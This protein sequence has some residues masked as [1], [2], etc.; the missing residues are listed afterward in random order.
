MS[1]TV[2]QRVMVRMLYDA[3]YARRVVH[4]PDDALAGEDLTPEE[5]EW[6]RKPDPRA[7]QADAERPSRSLTV[8]AQEYPTSI[9]LARSLGANADLF[10]GFFSSLEFHASVRNRGSMALAFGDWLVGLTLRSVVADRRLSALARLER[11]IVALRRDAP[12]R[13]PQIGLS[14][15]LYRTSPDK[16]VHVAP[17]GTADLHDELYERLPLSGA[18]LAAH[19]LRGRV[20]EPRTTVDPAA[21]EHLL[22]EF[23]REEGPRVKSPVGIAEITGGLAGLLGFAAHPATFDAL[24]AETIRLG[25]EPGEAGDVVASLVAEGTLV[26]V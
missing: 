6:L 16:S 12:A 9:A 8:L 15:R 13:A 2:L 22:L 20:D 11:G 3:S 24:C 26:P 10:L 7:W 1:H 17:A 21:T 5:R 18:D 23:A 25:A 4:E 14:S 19:V